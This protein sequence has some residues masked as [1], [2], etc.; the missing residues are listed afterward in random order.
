MEFGGIATLDSYGFGGGLE[1]IPKE[2]IVFLESCRDYYETERHFFAH[3]N[4]L[5]D[6]PLN[7]QPWQSL[8]WKSLRELPPKPHCSGKIAVVGHT[9]QASGEI[10][11]LGF[12]KCID[13]NCCEGG[14]LT[15]L[16]VNSGRVW[17]VS[18]RG[19]ARLR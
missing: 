1:Q 15:A 16:E 3:A 19:E 14:W 9:V 6:W 17:Q 18:E 11:D 12:M 4:Y 8:R 5:P 10:L 7:K 2:H 13:T